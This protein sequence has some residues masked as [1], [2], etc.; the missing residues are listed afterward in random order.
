MNE[1]DRFW[2]IRDVRV[3]RGR[4][5]PHRVSCFGRGR[6]RLPHLFQKEKFLMFEFSQLWWKR[7]VGA[8]CR[9]SVLEDTAVEK[10]LE[11][12]EIGQLLDPIQ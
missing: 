3:V 5:Y 7:M 4:G 9:Q 6:D 8:K 1:L 10:I 11:V 12:G 2:E